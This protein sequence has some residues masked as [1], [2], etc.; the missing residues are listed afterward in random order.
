MFLN[1]TTRRHG[2]KRGYGYRVAGTAY[3]VAGSG[4]RVAGTGSC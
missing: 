2:G 4:S 1:T 3:G